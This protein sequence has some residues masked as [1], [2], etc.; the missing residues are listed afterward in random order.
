MTK[1]CSFAAFALTGVSYLAAE[2]GD[3]IQAA[4]SFLT[5]MTLIF[6]VCMPL[7]KKLP[8]WARLMDEFSQD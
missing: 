7:D 5:A 6:F 1:I 4:V 3:H 2:Q 8:T